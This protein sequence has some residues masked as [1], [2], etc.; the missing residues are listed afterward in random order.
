MK[1]YADFLSFASTYNGKQ[2]KGTFQSQF[3][4][5]NTQNV[6]IRDRSYTHTDLVQYYID[7]V[8]LEPVYLQQY[9]DLA[10]YDGHF[11]MGYQNY[12]THTRYK[13]HGTHSIKHNEKL[14]GFICR[15]RSWSPFSQWQVIITYLH[16]TSQ[17]GTLTASDRHSSRKFHRKRHCKQLSASKTIKS[18]GYALLLD[19]ISNI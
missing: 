3:L 14:D 1:Y 9:H 12:K 10:Q 5:K 17:Y 2:V 19:S 16:H 13:R 18:H 6:T 8:Y 11:F 15:S 7:V 4:N